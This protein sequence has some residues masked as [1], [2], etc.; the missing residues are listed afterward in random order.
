[1]SEPQLVGEPPHEPRVHEVA[2]IQFEWADDIQIDVAEPGLIDGVLDDVA[3]SIVYGRSGAG[4]TA[5]MVDMACRIATG[6]PWRGHDTKPG[7]VLYIAA[8]NYKSTGH[9]ISGWRLMHKY[10]AGIPVIRT[11]STITL[12]GDAADRIIA[13]GRAASEQTGLPVRAVILDT[14]ARTLKGDENTSV[15]MGAY[16]QQADEIKVGLETNVIVVHH[17]GKDESRGSRGSSALKAAADHEIEISKGEGPQPGSMKLTKVR[18]G[19]LE[20]ER[21][22]FELFAQPLAQNRKGR[23]V[24]TPVVVEADAP[25]ERTG[26]KATPTEDTRKI[27]EAI[28]QAGKPLTLK[29]LKLLV[30][31]RSSPEANRQAWSRAKARG[32]FTED[33]MGYVV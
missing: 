4:K 27:R 32:V 19:E 33:H 29:E 12:E 11:R 23:L 5:L 9:R 18:E 30:P 8:E 15:D 3:L 21:Y 10:T 14:L 1:M 28:E 22:G 13:L 31:L 24:T 7:V 6:M 16:V 26:G 2:G 25:P 17:T 20:G